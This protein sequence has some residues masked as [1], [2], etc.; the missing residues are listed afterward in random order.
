MKRAALILAALFA[1]PAHAQDLSAEREAGL[2]CG[3]SD[4]VGEIAEAPDLGIKRANFWGATSRYPHGALGDDIEPMGLLVRPEGFGF[5]DRVFAMN[6]GVFEDIAPRLIDLDGDGQAEIIVVSSHPILGARLEIWGYPNGAGLGERFALQVIATTPYIGTRFRWLAPIGA[7]DLDG[8]GYLEIAY[9][10]RPHLAKTLRVWRYVDQ[11]LIPVAELEGL[12]NHRIGEDFI[13]GGI[14]DCGPVPE[15][16]VANA[17][18]SH[19]M[20]IRLKG[21]QLT[22]TEIDEYNGSFEDA[23]NCR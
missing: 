9:I 18:W 23:L 17:N 8:D 4:A 5:C 12:T 11:E 10:D 15:L 22:A 2:G 14:R 16:I 1:W 6:G 19:I 20:S 21:D 3:L 13:S 7:V